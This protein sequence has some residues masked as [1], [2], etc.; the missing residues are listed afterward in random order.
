[1]IQK[2]KSNQDVEWAP[3]NEDKASFREAHMDT[4]GHL[5]QTDMDAIDP[6][7]LNPKQATYWA[8]STGKDGKKHQFIEYHV[9][10]ANLGAFRLLYDYYEDIYYVTT[11]HYN[12]WG[13]GRNPFL[14]V[15][16]V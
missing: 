6:A 14:R 2:I 8:V 16:G 11:T 9:E 10:G 3:N 4:P 1:M 13:A 12:T 5:P 15:T 7:T